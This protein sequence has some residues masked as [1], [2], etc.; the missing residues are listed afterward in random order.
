MSALAVEDAK[1]AL[2]ALVLRRSEALERQ[3]EDRGHVGPDSSSI[4]ADHVD[5][6]PHEPR[7][8]DRRR[9][10]LAERR[11]GDGGLRRLKAWATLVASG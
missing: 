1:A 11:M 6:S 7:D 3:L 4:R 10:G 2:V 8:L 5:A 9:A